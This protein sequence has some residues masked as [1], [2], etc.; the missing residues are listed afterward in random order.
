MRRRPRGDPRHQGTRTGVRPRPA[1][2]PRA[3]DAGH[4]RRLGRPAGVRADIDREEV[5]RR[6]GTSAEAVRLR[7]DRGEAVAGGRARGGRAGRRPGRAGRVE[8]ILALGG[9]AGT[10]IG[11]AAMR[12]LPFGVPKVMVSTLA[13]GQTRP[14]VGGSDIVMVHPVADLAG[15]NRLTRTAPDQR[16][17]RAGRDGPAAGAPKPTRRTDRPVVAATMFGVTTPCVDRA[18][19]GSK[20]AGC[21]VVVFHAT[22]VG[23]Q[24]MEGLIRDGQVDGR[25]RPDD[26]RAGRRAGRRRPLGRARTARGGGPPGD[27]AGGQRRG[28]RHGELRAEGDRPRAV[29]RPPVPPPQ[30]VGDPDADDARGERRARAR[31]WPR[32]SAARSAPTVLLIPRGGVSALDAPG[33]P[34]HDPEAD[35]ALFRAP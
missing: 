33:R 25:A 2:R 23:G 35:A 19:Q 17:A 21:E 32:S 5:F 15:L 22:G 8:G 4:R 7:G 20:R 31:G 16:G 9:S 3:G 11:T 27:S 12:V 28:A 30:P 34:F 6:A 26:D 18:R 29:R 13:S 10:V 14:F 1:P 24:A